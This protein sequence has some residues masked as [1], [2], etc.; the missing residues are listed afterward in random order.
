[1]KSIQNF[2]EETTNR[3][4]LTTAAT[5][6]LDPDSDKALE[7]DK[8]HLDALYLVTKT[9][10]V[11]F[12]KLGDP[13]VLPYIHVIIVFIS[14]V[15]RFPNAIALFKNAKADLRNEKAYLKK[16]FL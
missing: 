1:M 4:E 2:S 3:A 5:P 14:Y 12:R 9:Y 16:Q 8:T 7:L 6:D 15:S 13:N 11:V 10:E